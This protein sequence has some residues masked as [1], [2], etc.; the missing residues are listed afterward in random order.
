MKTKQRIFFLLAVVTLLLLVLT[1]QAK[2]QESVSHAPTVTAGE[3]GLA[4]RYV[5]QFGTTE[6][7][8]I[9][10]GDH[11]FD[12][13][14]VT[15]D[16]N[17]NIW[18]SQWDGMRTSKFNSSGV[19]QF[20]IGQ[21]GFGNSD[22]EVLGSVG[23]T[24]VDSSGNIWVSEVE[25]HRVVKF[26]SAGEYQ[27]ELG[28]KWGSGSDN[29][30]F[31]SPR[32]LAFDSN[33][34]LY[35][36]DRYNHRIQ[37]YDSN[38]VYTATLG[39]SGVSGADNSHFDNPMRIHID[40]TDTLYIAD[41]GNHRV[42]IFDITNP[43][44]ITYAGT[45]GTVSESGSDNAHFDWPIGVTV[46]SNKIYVA[47]INNHRIQIFNITTNAYLAT[48]GTGSE[49]S[50]NGEFKAPSNVDVDS[51]GNIYVSEYRN[52]RVQK[53]NSS[54]A[55]VSTMGVTNVPYLTTAAHYNKPTGLATTDDGG[56][57]IVEQKGRRVIKINPDGS[58]AWAVG[59]A[60]VRGD[61]AQHFT[62]LYGVDVA[63]DGRIYVTE[64]WPNHRIHILNANGTHN[65]FFGSGYG[66][67]NDQFNGPRDVAFDS[68]GNIYV[69]DT[70]NHR[71]QIYDSN[72][73]YLSTI[74]ITGV[75]GSDYTHLNRPQAVA[76]DS[77]GTIY[78]G[79]SDNDRIQVFNS[80][81]VYQRTMGLG[82]C[83]DDFD[84]FCGVRGLDVDAQ[85]RLYVA[86]VYNN[87]VQVY[88]STGAYLTTIGG[89]WGGNLGEMRAVEGVAVD[90]NGNV[91]IGDSDNHRI[92]K[93]APGVLGWK[94]ININGFGDSQNWGAWTLGSFNDVLY[95]S[96][97]NFGTGAEVY[98]YISGNWEQVVSGGFGDSN[99]R[100]VDW[101]TEFNGSLY[102]GIWSEWDDSG[103]SGEIWRSSTGDNGSWTQVV[104]GGF[105]SINNIE[106][107]SLVEFDG[108]L[109]GGTWVA[110]TAVHRAEIWRSA[111]GDNASWARVVDDAVFGE[112][113]NIAIMSMETFN[114]NLYA[115]TLND[116]T[117]G[118]LWHTSNG[119]VW[120]QANTSGFGNGNN[121]RIVSLAVFDGNLYAGTRNEVA[122]GQLWRSANGTNWSL[123]TGNGFGNIENNEFASLTFFNNELIAVME[124][125]E[126]GAEVWRS[127]T[128]N[129]NDW[130]KVIDTG[131]G[132][133][134]AV[135]IGYDGITAVVGNQLYIGAGTRWGN[136]GG[137]VWQMQRQVFL[138]VVIR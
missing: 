12:P 15:I 7:P 88:D 93:Y 136:G 2:E 10:D 108:Y 47:D 73:N 48:I 91:Y 121:T 24:A 28:H 68:N 130:Q 61:D 16:G 34:N 129:S 31:D 66:T 3:P 42:Q 125:Y 59:V 127:A 70:N 64:D 83:G 6:I 134:A 133:G 79:D 13:S 101:F 4:F 38:G 138:P 39:T 17:D 86:D 56:L 50:G 18:V 23:D 49:G 32:G 122:G 87:R 81:Y 100:G 62:E 97:G 109:Y 110:D 131:F 119:T 8:Y 21:A 54:Y 102:A 26:N 51:N 45:I 99:N 111:S 126:T 115:A 120:T 78:I 89:K 84:H 104:D 36:S 137:R 76:I 43:S 117:G 118:E 52:H 95:A 20:S 1:V 5:E 63:E 96:T 132:G 135:S 128:G 71:V 69:A 41:G 105:D 74:G 94:Q 113:Q 114:G 107:Q 35:I 72:H 19:Y 46:D 58:Q 67:D 30:H 80:N 123:V 82:G 103:S 112:S 98:R 57:I 25:D 14:S 77:T 75:S 40:S 65:S 90:D 124:N 9:A 37:I 33:G 27:S 53:F 22:G 44:T 29:D 11:L 55:Y 60:G 85:N 106:V 116:A 92:Y